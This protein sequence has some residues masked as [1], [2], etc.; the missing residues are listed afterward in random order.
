MSSLITEFIEK[1]DGDV[2]AA[3]A[4]MLQ[5]LMADGPNFKLGYTAGNA[6]AA[7][8]EQFGNAGINVDPMLLVD[9]AFPKPIKPQVYVS[10]SGGIA[11]AMI[12][13]PTYNFEIEANGFK[14]DDN[15]PVDI[16]LIDWDHWEDDVPE[17]DVLEDLVDSALRL[18]GSHDESAITQMAEQIEKDLDGGGYPDDGSDPSD[19]WLVTQQLNRL[20]EVTNATAH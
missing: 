6:Y 7:V 17:P 19:A 11:E 1:H 14:G 15:A 18:K 20:K 13:R 16:V 9:A 3:A 12:T 4:D 10:V 2:H 8:L 5:R